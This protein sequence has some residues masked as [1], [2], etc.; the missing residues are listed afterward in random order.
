ML[1]LWKLMFNHEST[2][3][4]GLFHPTTFGVKKRLFKLIVQC[5]MK[6]IFLENFKILIIQLS[7]DFV[8]IF[9]S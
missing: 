8:F 3:G 5:V 1:E 2:I 7:N 4:D 9:K 6:N